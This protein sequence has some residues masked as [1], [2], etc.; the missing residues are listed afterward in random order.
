MCGVLVIFS[1]K[2]SL[3]KKKCS[4]SFNAIKNRGPD[5]SVSK[6]FLNNKLFIG[7]TILQITGKVDNKT[8]SACEDKRFYISFNGEI[9]NY[10]NLTKLN[11][12]SISA[13]NDT[14]KIIKLHKYNSPINILKSIEGMFAYAVYN[15]HNKTLYYA[16]DSQGEKKLFSYED[17]NYFI[18]SSNIN[19]ILKFFSKKFKVNEQ[20]IYD[21]LNSR[22]LLTDGDTFYKKIKLLDGAFLYTKDLETY[23]S[24][25]KKFDDPLNWIDEKYYRKLNSNKEI[26]NINLLD[27]L[28]K[29]YSKLLKPT[30][31]FASIFTGG[32]DSS[33]QASYFFKE[34]KLKK[35]ICID[36]I[37][38]DMITKEIEKFNKY[39]KKNITKILCNEKI[40]YSKLQEVY[41]KL[42]IPFPS[43]DVIG[44][45]LVY[46]FLKSQKIK[47]SFGASGADELF[48]GYEA[49]KTINWCSGKIQN[50][51][52]Y[53]NF[54]TKESNKYSKISQAS[55]LLWKKAFK[56][57]S[58]FLNNTEAKMQASLFTDYFI[59]GIKRDNIVTDI[60]SMSHG[61][62]VRNIFLN[63]NIIKFCLNLPI[64]YKINLRE[65]N[66]L[67]VC[68]PILKKLFIRKFARKLVFKKQ[69]FSGF[70]NESIKYAS[71]I[72]QREFSNILK[73]IHKKSELTEFKANEWKFL[74]LFY[75]SKFLGIKINIKKFVKNI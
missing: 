20:Q 74:N 23:K 31:K 61:V 22:H 9:Y 47:V 75:F 18:L 63:K 58:K 59:Q 28:F 67:M 48:G 60:I 52:P 71:K 16:T 30:I 73:L 34:K 21:Y 33:L 3:N 14:S 66:E 13:S 53:S 45:H 10:K 6:Y 35:L 64:K 19:A 17:S 69:G 7:N 1:K 44:H 65:K 15:N 56:K 25:K 50:L 39:T 4:L 27:K 68:K 46:S 26:Q 41:K 54:K 70:P 40:Y 43:H 51:S 62:E 72:Y 36:H 29:K 49:Y 38:K 5:F 32:V 57:Y 8:L 24:K 37:K 42:Y 55:N 12:F 11:R 2:S